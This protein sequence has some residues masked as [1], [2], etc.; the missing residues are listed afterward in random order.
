MAR[1]IRE[2][3]LIVYQPEGTMFPMVRASGFEVELEPGESLKDFLTQLARRRLQHGTRFHHP[4]V[5]DETPPP[6]V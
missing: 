2:G 4:L 1:V 5:I 6:E 3:E